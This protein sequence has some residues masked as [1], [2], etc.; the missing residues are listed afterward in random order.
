MKHWSEIYREKLLTTDGAAALIEPGDRIFAGGSGCIAGTLL[1]AV[2]ARPELSDVL[3][4]T[5][6]NSSVCRCLTERDCA[7]RMEY[8]SLFLGS[9]DRELMKTGRIRINSVQFHNASRAAIEVYGVN[10]LMLQV[11]EPDDDGYLYYGTRGIAWSTLDGLVEKRIFQINSN[12]QKIR[13]VHNRIHVSEVTALCREDAPL[14]SYAYKEPDETDGRIAAH[15]VPHIHSGD[16]LQVGIGGIPNAVAYSLRRHKDLGIYT[17]VLTESQMYLMKCGA[18]DLD[19]VTAGF[20]LSS[21]GKVDEDILGHIVFMPVDLLNRPD[22][23]GSNPGLVSVNGCLMADLTGQVCAENI[24]GRQVSGVGGQLDFVRAAAISKGGRSFLCMRSA[25]TGP[26]GAESSNIRSVLPPGAI[27]TTPRTDVMNVVTEWGVAQLRDR[28]FDERALAMIR[29]AHPKFRR[30][31]A[32]EAVGLGLL[33]P[34]QA[35]D[36]DIYTKNVEQ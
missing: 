8:H 2:A 35:G 36:E 24:D 1:D 21:T 5:A 12:Q 20:A 22:K 27:V 18:V 16:V 9:A 14:P 32:A 29:I 15:I 23:A 7:D 25:F 13:G 10:T 34:E 31:L 33:R 28:P 17:E 26:D 11:S 3:V 6:M 4:L 30:Q 19:R